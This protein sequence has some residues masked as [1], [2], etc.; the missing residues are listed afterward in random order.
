MITTKQRSEL[1]AIAQNL[2]PSFNIGKDNLSE[3]LIIAINDYLNKNELVKIKI[4]QNSEED[5]RE[6]MEEICFKLSAEPVLCI[7][8]TVIIYRF[9]EKNK[10]HI[11]N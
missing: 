7:G 11:L 4:L 5:T 1:K 8:K 2:K 10:K 6:V 9:N 3:N